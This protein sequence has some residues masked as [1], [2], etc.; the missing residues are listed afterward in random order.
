MVL[1]DKYAARSE[2]RR[3]ISA[4]VEQHDRIVRVI[5]RIVKRNVPARRVI[6]AAKVFGRQSDNFRFRLLD[7]EQ[8]EILFDQPTCSPRLIDECNELGASG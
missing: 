5:G 4:E 6:A 1:S 8:V 3:T 2:Q 7:S